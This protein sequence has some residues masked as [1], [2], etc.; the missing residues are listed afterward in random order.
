MTTGWPQ[1]GQD[2]QR[3]PYSETEATPGLLA[4][5]AAVAAIRTQG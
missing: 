1:H 4:L 3:T 5:T 2:L